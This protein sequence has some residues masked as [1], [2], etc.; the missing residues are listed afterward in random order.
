MAKKNLKMPPKNTTPKILSFEPPFQF[1]D[2]W[3][4][5]ILSLC[6]NDFD[7]FSIVNLLL[8]IMVLIFS[9]PETI[10]DHWN[11]CSDDLS[12]SENPSSNLR[13]RNIICFSDVH[14]IISKTITNLATHHVLPVN[15][16]FMAFAMR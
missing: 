13:V 4:K 1:I 11:H 2:F 9:I 7:N 5:I 15:K 16:L 10:L 6:N 8:R 12:D 3:R 14:S